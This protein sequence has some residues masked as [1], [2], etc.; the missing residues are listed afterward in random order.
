MSTSTR[1][2]DT[3]DPGAGRRPDASMTLLTEMLERP[4]DPAYARVA[5]RREAQ[6]LPASPGHRSVLLIVTVLVIGLVMGVSAATLR[7]NA[8]TRSQARAE[9][10]HQI[11]AARESRDSRATTVSRLSAEVA[12][13]GAAVLAAE[14]AAQGSQLT[15][16]SFATGAQAAVGPG[17]VVTI[18]DAPSAAGAGSKT[19][20]R[21]NT[22]AEDGVVRARDLQIIVNSLWAAGAEAVMVNG[23]RLTSTSAIRFAG[24][25]LLVNYRPLVRPY[26][27]SAIGDPAGLPARF[28]EG[29]GG[30]YAAT[31]SSSFGIVVDTETARELRLPAAASVQVRLAEPLAPEP[32]GTPVQGSSPAGTGPPSSGDSSSTPSSP[33]SGGSS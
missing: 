26:V 24:Q 31:L 15:A 5:R 23:Q 4:L 1:R 33:S 12:E 14:S 30:T 19:D 28:A 11:E 9:L 13:R 16:L 21:A 2:P 7:G 20:P 25:A 17:L 8:T 27:I 3:S 10:A 22:R 6:G 29:P 18:D 32:S